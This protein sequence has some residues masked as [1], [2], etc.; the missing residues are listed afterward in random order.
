MFVVIVNIF[1]SILGLL[2][3]CMEIILIVGYIEFEKVYIVCEYL[4]LK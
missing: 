1:L 4:L 2:F 3:D